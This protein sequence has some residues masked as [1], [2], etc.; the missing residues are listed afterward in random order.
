MDNN[1]KKLVTFE[2]TPSIWQSLKVEAYRRGKT[3]KE[4]LNE[5]IAKF[6]KENNGG[7]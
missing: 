3:V 6:L 4:V 1:A 5:L 2:T 7:K